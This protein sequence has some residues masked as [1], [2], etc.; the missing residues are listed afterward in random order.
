MSKKPENKDPLLP[1]KYVGYCRAI[2]PP[3]ADTMTIEDF[4]DFCK[5]FLCRKTRTLWKDPIWDTYTDEEIMAEYFSYQFVEDED[6]RIEFEKV[7][8]II[9]ESGIYD[10]LDEMV[11][12]NQAETARVLEEM[13]E[14]VSFTP[15][16]IG[17]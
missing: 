10:W 13:E 3:G 11:E 8:D 2:T 6:A 14:N 12:K 7:S 4:V 15:D 17:D 5:S 9:V 16:T 1:L